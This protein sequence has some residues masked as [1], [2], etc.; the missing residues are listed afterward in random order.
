[1]RSDGNEIK[2]HNEEK[3]WLRN[4][5]SMIGYYTRTSD[6]YVKSLGKK[7]NTAVEFH[8][9]YVCVCVLYCKC[10]KRWFAFCCIAGIDEKGNRNVRELRSIRH[11][12]NAELDKEAIVSVIQCACADAE[13]HLIIQKHCKKK[14]AKIIMVSPITGIF[15]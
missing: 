15:V 2:H 14:N 11:V 10:E 13:T 1:M 12:H 6:S 3:S 7:T 9:A 4:E 8:N 5:R